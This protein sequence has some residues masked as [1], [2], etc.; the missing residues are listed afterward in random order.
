MKKQPSSFSYGKLFGLTQYVIAFLKK[1]SKALA[2]LNKILMSIPASMDEGLFAVAVDLGS[3]YK[4]ANSKGTYAHTWSERNTPLKIFL[5][6][7]RFYLLW[8]N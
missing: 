8:L 3:L 1:R 4:E 2:A 5:S 7:M 6:D